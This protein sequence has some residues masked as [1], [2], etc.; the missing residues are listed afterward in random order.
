ME[1]FVD[2]LLACVHPP[3]GR[4]KAYSLTFNR[5]KIETILDTCRQVPERRVV[6]I[7]DEIIDSIH[8]S[9]S[10]IVDPEGKKIE[11]SPET[12]VI[13]N[14]RMMLMLWEYSKGKEIGTNAA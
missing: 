12:L 7:M 6:E 14:R 1:E 5:K 13:N 4:R 10:F 8:A 9:T 2:K 11:I 3:K